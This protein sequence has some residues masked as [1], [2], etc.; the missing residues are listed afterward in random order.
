MKRI[1]ATLMILAFLPVFAFAQTGILPVFDNKSTFK[2]MPQMTAVNPANRNISINKNS[3][4]YSLSSSTIMKTTFQSAQFSVAGEVN[5]I[6]Y[7]PISKTTMFILN[8]LSHKAPYIFCK[9]R[10]RIPSNQSMQQ[11][12]PK[13]F[14]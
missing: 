2:L 11:R 5:P 8:L 6:V 9:V 3:K 7:D 4:D 10:P 13:S 14:Q 12:V 1:I